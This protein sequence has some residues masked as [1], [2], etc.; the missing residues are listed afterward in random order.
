MTTLEMIERL[1]RQGVELKVRG[2][3]LQCIAPKGVLTEQDRGDLTRH[4]RKILD[5]LRQQNLSAASSVPVLKPV[6]RKSDL[7]LSFAQERLWFLEQ[8]EGDRTVYDMPAAWRLKGNQDVEALRRALET[9]VARHEPLRTVIRSR[10]GESFLVIRQGERFELP[11]CN[12]NKIPGG[13]RESEVARL[14]REEARRPFDLEN[15]LMLRARLLRLSGEEHVLLMTQH[16]I[17]SVGWSQQILWKELQLLYGAFERGESSP[18]PGLPSNYSEYTQWQR[19]QLQG[20]TRERLLTYWRKQLEELTPLELSA[21]RPRLP[22]PSYR[23]AQ[24]L[25]RLDRSLVD[26]LRKLGAVSGAT[27]H[28]TMLAAFQVLLARCSGQEDI[29]VGIPIASRPAT[30]FEPLIGLFVNTLVLRGDLSG[31]PTFNEFLKRVRTTS[32]AAYEHQEL[33]FEMLV[34]ELQPERHPSRN[35]L[36]QVLFNMWEDI[37]GDQSHLS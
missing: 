34:Q 16:H 6:P 32:V 35:P 4:K 33:P 28:M 3:R 13:A 19:N 5:Y 25:T 23:G 24:Q 14:V 11:V 31:E 29:A 22:R 21:D 26:R 27:L 20:V 10:D 8:L 7:P 15:D 36:F 18:L 37:A 2:D 12:L 17:A 1:Q 9:I 30:A